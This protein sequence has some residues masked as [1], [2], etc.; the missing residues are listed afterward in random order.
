MLGA[1]RIPQEYIKEWK[2]IIDEFAK[3]KGIIDQSNKDGTYPKESIP[4]LQQAINRAK[5]FMQ[6]IYEEHLPNG[7]DKKDKQKE[8]RGIY[9]VD[10]N[11]KNS[12]LIKS[13]KKSKKDAQYEL[14]FEGR[15]KI[16]KSTGKGSFHNEKHRTKGSFGELN[17]N[18]EKHNHG[19]VYRHGKEN[20]I[21][22]SKDRDKYK[23]EHTNYSNNE[24]F[25]VISGGD[26]NSDEDTIISTHSK[27][28]D[29]KGA[30]GNQ[31]SLV[32]TYSP[33]TQ[34]STPHKATHATSTSIGKN[35]ILKNSQTVKNS[36]EKRAENLINNNNFKSIKKDILQSKDKSIHN[37]I[38]NNMIKKE[39]NLR[40]NNQ[41]THIYNHRLD[42][43]IPP[44]YQN[45]T[46]K[47]L[48]HNEK[49]IKDKNG[50]KHQNILN[51]NRHKPH[52][53]NQYQKYLKN[54]NII[55]NISSHTP[56]DIL[57]AKKENEIF[58]KSHTP[59][60]G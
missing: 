34:K 42:I 57:I 35:I 37:S 5:D 41:N 2:E 20:I 46:T 6:S 51:T 16:G 39:L 32:I 10:N 27:R 4:L 12:T 43:P 14:G 44:K 21:V 58:L 17:N 53:N 3:H 60:E 11:N 47:A 28:N 38:N 25:R 52:S 7:L 9:N 23:V 50:K 49:Y 13:N 56:F 19:G 33:S 48:K 1:L 54:K 18:I 31:T 30:K 22:N 26:V 36:I 8:I 29:P 59:Y 24:R 15:N 40:K 55:N 45:Q